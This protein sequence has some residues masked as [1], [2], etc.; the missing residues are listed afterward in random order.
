MACQTLESLSIGPYTLESGQ[1]CVE[2]LTSGTA[3]LTLKLGPF[4]YTKTIPWYSLNSQSLQLLGTSSGRI[5]LIGTNPVASFFVDDILTLTEYAQ[6][7]ASALGYPGSFQIV[8][9]GITSDMA[10][11][12]CKDCVVYVDYVASS[13]PLAI[14]LVVALVIIFVIA[15]ILGIY[16]ISAAIE[17]F[18][19]APPTPPPPGSSQ[20]LYQQYYQAYE[21][22]LQEKQTAS[23]T[24]SI[25]G[26]STA[27]AVLGVALL[28][29]LALSGGGNNR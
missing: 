3:T 17:S 24:G 9:V 29:F 10:P 27:V 4:S 15:I 16:F 8:N 7:V 25:F 6:K 23:V 28:T 14:A 26:T 11:A 18:Q 1:V 20:T 2:G 19:P 21:Q 12:G 22:Y 5:Y 13:P